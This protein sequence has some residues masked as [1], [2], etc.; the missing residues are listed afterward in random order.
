[1]RPLPRIGLDLRAGRDNWLGGLYYLRNL[2][3]AVKSLPAGEQPE[4]IGLLPVD[5]PDVRSEALADILEF[6]PFRGGEP[7]ASPAGK[8]R[9]RLRRLLDSG[10]DVP[11]G[12]ERAIL[13]A[14]IEV[15]FP[16]LTRSLRSDVAQLP[17]FYDLQH[18]HE[19]G[20][21]SRS[22]RTARNRTFKRIAESAK[23]IV[24]S[25]SVGAD[26]IARQYPRAT[27]KL[28]V[29][30]F[31]TVLEENW[32]DSDPSHI[33]A[34]Y[35]LRE[36]FLLCPGQFW[37]HKDHR[38]AFDSIRILRDSGV[39][40]CLVCTGHTSDYRRPTYFRTLETFA[41]DHGLQDHIRILGVL[42]RSDYIQLLRATRLVV[43][44]SVY[45]GW[46][47]VVEDA[48]ALGKRIVLS[49]IPVHAE[50]APEG[51]RYFRA[52]DA[53]GLAA[54]IRDALS[55]DAAITSE[56][57]SRTSQHIRTLDYA[58]RFVAIAKE[59][60]ATSDRATP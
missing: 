37:I 5:D 53:A 30:R 34:Q 41:S 26:E 7:Q 20:N 31:T 10:G 1:M 32:F 35:G 46:S 57:A 49:D 44:P 24:V 28:R 33:A 55:L 60:V 56:L 17:W 51:G 23:L 13:K 40:V 54:C 14:G 22:E 9:N 6:V 8:V 19:P 50:Q 29:L 47:S 25:S 3:L 21:F 58:R 2:I 12:I 59:V 15:I 27:D 45:E 52:G 16:M 4:L 42:P 18:L 38:V 39:D 48:R 43:Q 11:F 36:G